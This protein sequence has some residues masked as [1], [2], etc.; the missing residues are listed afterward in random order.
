MPEPNSS[1]NPSSGP[2][3]HHL[4]GNAGDERPESQP[5]LDEGRTPVLRH[6]RHGVAGV[7]VAGAEPVGGPAGV[8]R[9]RLAVRVQ[10]TLVE[11]AERL[12]AGSERVETAAR[13][14][15]ACAD[16]AERGDLDLCEAVLI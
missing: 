13:G 14:L 11:L 7:P 4:D 1:E 12:L 16:G 10:V 9:R 6:V 3:V 8:V 5:V 15:E 2:E